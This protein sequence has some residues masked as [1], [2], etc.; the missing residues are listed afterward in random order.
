[1][2]ESKLFYEDLCVNVD[3]FADLIDSEVMRI[4]SMLTLR[5]KHD[6]VAVG[7]MIV[8][9]C[10]LKHETL[11]VCAVDLNVDTVIPDWMSTRRP[12]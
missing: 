11:N 9:G 10:Q 12:F 6:H 1:M 5:C 3:E 4:H 7:R 2:L 8:A